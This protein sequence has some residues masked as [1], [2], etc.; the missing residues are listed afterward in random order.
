LP[1]E[2]MRLALRTPT[3]VAAAETVVHRIASGNRTVK[4]SY[5]VSLYFK[6]DDTLLKKARRSRRYLKPYLNLILPSED[7]REYFRSKAWP[8]AIAYLVRPLRLAAKYGT[9]PRRAFSKLKEWF[10]AMD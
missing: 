10:G 8:S 2:V 3:V 6:L 5:R 9:A 7:D 4:D 1:E